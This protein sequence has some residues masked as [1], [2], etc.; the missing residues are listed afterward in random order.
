MESAKDHSAK[1]ETVRVWQRW[2]RARR[3]R[4][5]DNAALELWQ[6]C[7]N[8]IWGAAKEL[9]R[10]FG[11]E[12]PMTVPVWRLR[13]GLSEDDIRYAAFPAVMK[14]AKGFDPRKGAAFQ[15]YA[16]KF[17][18]GELRSFV[19]AEDVL[20]STTENV[21][22]NTEDGQ[23][24]AEDE[25]P[26]Q[27]EP[28]D[29]WCLLELDSD[30]GGPDQRSD[31]GNCLAGAHHV[32]LRQL[33][34]WLEENRERAKEQYG[35]G[36]WGF[37]HLYAGWAAMVD[38][39]SPELRHQ[40]VFEGMSSVGPLQGVTIRADGKK[41]DHMPAV[42]ADMLLRAGVK[43]SAVAKLLDQPWS[44]FKDMKKRMDELGFDSSRFTLDQADV[45][46]RG[47]PRGRP[48]KKPST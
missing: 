6:L 13:N 11:G 28:R 43:K 21:L 12:Q 25:Q 19:A 36:R 29:M 1:Q 24:I 3:R 32:E 40:K 37:L 35:Y 47:K 20:F 5:R 18:L 10:K 38:E 27:K 44:T 26:I 4:E 9:A 42:Q 46:V 34:G 7:E 17:I 16:Y 41:W 45:A 8:E 48:P 33:Q 15:T 14:A 22:F 39:M 30:N 31:L 2:R 23:D